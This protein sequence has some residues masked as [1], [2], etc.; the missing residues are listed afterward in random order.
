MWPNP[1]ESADLVTFTDEILDGILHFLCSVGLVHLLK[2]F[3][4]ALLES[5]QTSTM[6]LF[7][8]TCF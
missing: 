2:L 4:E 6:K 7:A 3:A 1:Q 8:K 5:T